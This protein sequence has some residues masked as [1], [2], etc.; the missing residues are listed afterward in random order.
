MKGHVRHNYNCY[1]AVAHSVLVQLVYP[2]RS[3][4]LRLSV[5]TVQAETTGGH[6]SALCP[7]SV[8]HGTGAL[9]APGGLVVAARH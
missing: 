7:R 1:S 5:T 2:A 8:G 4:V 6:L 3:R 9:E